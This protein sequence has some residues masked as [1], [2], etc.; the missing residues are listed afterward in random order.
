M[1]TRISCIDVCSLQKIYAKLA[2][3]SIVTF[4]PE[5][6]YGAR[7]SHTC[8]SIDIPPTENPNGISRYSNGNPLF[9]GMFIRA[10]HTYL[11]VAS[12]TILMR[13]PYFPG[14][15]GINTFRHVLPRNKLS[16][17][18]NVKL[19]P[20][21]MEYIGTFNINCICVS[22]L[23]HTWRVHFLQVGYETTPNPLDWRYQITSCS[24]LIHMVKIFESHIPHEMTKALP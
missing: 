23:C 9:T 5:P 14:L 12:V 1:R 22:H 8:S 18:S 17:S 7:I 20:V 21:S 19:Q 2:H 13:K 6:K 24:L 16:I 10:L 4:R 3:R 11:V 15:V